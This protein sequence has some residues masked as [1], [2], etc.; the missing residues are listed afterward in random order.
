MA[1]FGLFGK[2]KKKKEEISPAAMPEYPTGLPPATEEFGLP[3]HP[4]PAPAQA[5]TE[6]AP[7][8][9]RAES[10]VATSKDIEVLNAKLDA[11]KALLESIHQRLA[12][13]ERLAQ[14]SKEHEYKYY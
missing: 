2:K 12:A 3:S 6:L 11:L 5:S 10:G 8:M 4:A 1:F 9:Q 14:E 7:L 13:L